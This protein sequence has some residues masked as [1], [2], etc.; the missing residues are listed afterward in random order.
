MNSGKPLEYIEA[1]IGVPFALA[2]AVCNFIVENIVS[3]LVLEEEED[4]AIVDITF[5]VPAQEKEKYRGPLSDYLSQLVCVEM[6]SVPEVRER[7]IQDINWIEKYKA[8]VEPIR[9]GTDILVRPL[10]QLPDEETRYDIVIEPKMAFGTG[11]HETTRSCLAFIREYFRSGMR[12]LDLG[13]GSGILSILADMMGAKY[14]KAI[15]YDLTAIENCRENFKIN[16]VSAVHD[17]LFGSIEKCE[18]DEPYE[19]VCSNIIKSTILPIL[20]RLLS[21]TTTG[22]ILVLSGLL[23]EDEAEITNSLSQQGQSSFEIHRD[24]RWLTYFLRKG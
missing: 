19:F 21:L 5:Y 9:V 4:G 23:E 12:F 8:S 10:W 3:G 17:I 14:I 15:D 13:T 6:P 24:N 2:D 7:T 16:H 1:R 11:S 20:P 18:R 22:G